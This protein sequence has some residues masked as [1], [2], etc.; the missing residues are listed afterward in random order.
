MAKCV[1]CHKEIADDAKFCMYC[2]AEQVTPDIVCRECGK[3][4]DKEASFCPHCGA[5]QDTCKNCGKPLLKGQKH[6]PHCG[7]KVGSKTYNCSCGQKDIP[8]EYDF[9]PN[10]GKSRVYDILIER[11][12]KYDKIIDNVNG[13]DI[14]LLFVPYKGKGTIFLNDIERATALVDTYGAGKGFYKTEAGKGG[15]NTKEISVKYLGQLLSL[16]VQADITK[17][18]E[19]PNGQSF[20]DNG[21]DFAKEMDKVAKHTSVVVQD[22]GSKP[23]NDGEK[24]DIL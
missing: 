5:A 21:W 4:I 20:T 17:G 23:S 3:S 8:Y 9:C 6:C 24:I 22:S 11:V 19:L 1:H 13:K 18:I 16:Y 12:T 14:H 2:G 7:K 15:I 10:C